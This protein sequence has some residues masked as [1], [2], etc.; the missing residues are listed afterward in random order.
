MG[1][2]SLSEDGIGKFDQIKGTTYD[3][4]FDEFKEKP[5]EGYVRRNRPGTTKNVS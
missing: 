2:N 1:M 5:S 3:T 4:N